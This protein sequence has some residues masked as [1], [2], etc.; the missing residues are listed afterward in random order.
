MIRPLRIALF[1]PDLRPLAGGPPRVVLGSA[2]ALVARGHAVTIFTLAAGAVDTPGVEICRFPVDR[3]AQFGR[4]R[5]MQRA[6]RQRIAEFDALHV[7][8]V[9]EAGAADLAAVFRAAGKPVIVSA[10]GMLD[11]WSMAQS[12]LKKLVA[13]RLWTGRLLSQAAAIVFATGE[14][15]AEASDLYPK[16]PRAIIANGIDIA[17]TCAAITA[18]REAVRRTV[19]G[20]SVWPR[21]IV[22]LSR[23]HPKKGVDQLV[24]ARL[25][26]DSRFDDVGLLIAGIPQ[27]DALLQT[28]RSRIAG[29]S[30]SDRI[31][32]TTD[33]VGPVAMGALGAAQL[34][35]LPSHQ[36]GFSVAILEAMA[37]GLP[38]LITDKCHLPEVE[39]WQAGAVVPDTIAGVKAG[40]ER[41][42]LL[43]ADALAAAGHNARA[44]V[45]RHYGWPVI[46]GQLET[47][48]AQGTPRP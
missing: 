22:Y 45:E 38:V 25:A 24:E 41:L 6:A 30:F 37:A 11:H 2:Q 5:A 10:H 17:A 8:A 1:T 47:L 40:L 28:L 19:P 27:D 16:T 43:S 21:T 12:R 46:A 14:E 39:E 18:G 32:L 29:S 44:V 9:W 7:H 13:L 23:L 4:S 15:A 36:E 20:L 34:F 26:L 3:P 31:T 35:V 33:L 42:L 48:Y